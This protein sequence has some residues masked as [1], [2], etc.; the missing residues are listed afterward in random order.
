MSCNIGSGLTFKQT[1]TIECMH[2]MEWCIQ[3]LPEEVRKIGR[4]FS[5]PQVMLKVQ[6][7][8]R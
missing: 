1:V 3:L 4:L 5:D 7:S 8:C 2:S 6:I